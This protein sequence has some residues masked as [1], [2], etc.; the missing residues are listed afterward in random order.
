MDSCRG[1]DKVHHFCSQTDKLTSLTHQR[2][3]PEVDIG[4][5]KWFASPHVLNFREIWK[6]R[7]PSVDRCARSEETEGIG[8][9]EIESSTL[10]V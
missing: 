1:E 6:E 5:E 7:E 3:R 9:V 2:V 8:T 10:R 4:R